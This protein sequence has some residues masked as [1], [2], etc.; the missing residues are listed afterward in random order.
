MDSWRG[1]TRKNVTKK[2]IYN[3]NNWEGRATS[4]VSI[5]KILGEALQTLSSLVIAIAGEFF[6]SIIIVGARSY[7]VTYPVVMALIPVMASMRGGLYSTLGA[8]ASTKLHLGEMLK[9]LRDRW[10]VEQYAA[11]LTLIPMIALYVAIILSIISLGLSHFS[12]VFYA[13]TMSSLIAMF[14]LFPFTVLLAIRTFKKGWDPDNVLSP[15][16]ALVG[17]ITTIPTLIIVVILYY[18]TSI[19]F[20]YALLIILFVLSMLPILK[21]DGSVNIFRKSVSLE[22][23]LFSALIIA[24][25]IEVFT[26]GLLVKYTKPLVTHIALLGA[27]PVMM[28]ATGSLASISASKIGTRLHLGLYPMN[29]GPSKELVE[30]VYH[31]LLQYPI[32]YT[33]V[34]L[35]GVTSSLLLGLTPEIIYTFG[36][37]LVA[38]LL[39]QPIIIFSSH[40][41]SIL[42]FKRRL[43]PDNVTIPIL[44]AL[45][46][47]T[48]VFMVTLIISI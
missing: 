25:T 3:K 40:C 38:G 27:L 17:D 10:I 12:E 14:V 37:I 28:Q 35:T 47:V 7:L 32:A 45:M 31:V 44:T 26:G 18:K 24:I 43:D 36:V 34:A 4:E 6:Y 22:R 23:Q 41:I 33:L 20:S 19:H 30:I 2:S 29:F 15:L 8:R 11:V 42:A 39:L 16:I 9:E 5:K 21:K 46:D 13:S 48:S 1:G